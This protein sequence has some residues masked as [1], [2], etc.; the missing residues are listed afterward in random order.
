VNS[1]IRIP[2]FSAAVIAALVV[3]AGCQQDASLHGRAPEPAARPARDSEP[4]ARRSSVLYARGSS[5]RLAGRGSEDRLVAK[6]PAPDI[7][8]A[9]GSDLV[10]YVDGTGPQ[11]HPDFLTRPVVHVVDLT[12]GRDATV[13]RGVVPL[14]APAG[15]ALAY[16]EPVGRRRC[17]AETCAGSVRVV[18]YDPATEMRR[19]LLGP[20][21]WGLLAWA[22]RD[23]LVADLDDPDAVL[24]VPPAGERLELP[25]A[26]SELWD[27]SPDGR[28]L[29]RSRPGEAAFLPMGEGGVG[30]AEIPIPVGEGTLADGAWAPDSSAVAAILLRP[31]RRGG[32]RIVTFSPE[33]P[34]PDPI[35]GSEGAVGDVVWDVHGE[36]LAFATA[37]PR[38]RGALSVRLCRLGGGC[39]EVLSWM[40]GV[41]LLRVE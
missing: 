26:P 40:A 9:Q 27:S 4:E 6:L 25:L 33:D 3:G 20:G 13:G 19:T 1:R 7:R 28:W 8:A 30:G 22:G 10:A 32:P 15:E 2:G 5:L 11:D 14:W 37:S 21:R 36:Q 41:R 12:S 17:E 31:A 34:V 38:S 35:P 16:L 29:V 18:V 23:L 39:R 24:A